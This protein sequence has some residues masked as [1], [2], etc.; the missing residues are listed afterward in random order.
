MGQMST[1]FQCLSISDNG[2]QRLALAKG[3]VKGGKIT[4]G[5]LLSIDLS[6]TFSM[7]VPIVQVPILA[8]FYPDW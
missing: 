6:G 1:Y 5:M 7:T 8:C 4:A 2:D 3:H